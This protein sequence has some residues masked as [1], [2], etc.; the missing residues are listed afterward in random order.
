[1]TTQD[2]GPLYDL[3]RAARAAGFGDDLDFGREI[4]RRFR[5]ALTQRQSRDLAATF[6]EFVDQIADMWERNPVENALW[7]ATVSGIY[8]ALA[9]DY[10]A[11]VREARGA[12]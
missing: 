1:M 7:L 8:D 9:K 4:A 12:Q 11:Q 3:D 2:T 6:G 5:A 10:K